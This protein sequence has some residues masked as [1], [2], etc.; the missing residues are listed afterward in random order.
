MDGRQPWKQRQRP[1][2]SA[3]QNQQSGKAAQNV[4]ASVLARRC[5]PLS[6]SCAPEFCTSSSMYSPA[7][8]RNGQTK[9]RRGNQS[10]TNILVPNTP[11]QTVHTA[12]IPQVTRVT[13]ALK[14]RP[15]LPSPNHDGTQKTSFTPFPQATTV[16]NPQPTDSTHLFHT[17]DVLPTY[18][19]CTC[20]KKTKTNSNL[21]LTPQR[22]LF[23]RRGV[24]QSVAILPCAVLCTG[25]QQKKLSVRMNT[26]NNTFIHVSVTRTVPALT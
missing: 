26:F 2:H 8:N 3:R 6:C 24:R 7:S 19:F 17:G 10:Y 21:A 16:F 15:P 12:S 14:M 18:F 23:F 9:R 13:L 5:P 25:Q 20:P 4:C 11:P 22:S 1:S